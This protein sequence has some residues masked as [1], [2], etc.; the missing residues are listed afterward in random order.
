MAEERPRQSEA[1]Y[2]SLIRDHKAVKL[3]IDPQDGRIVDANRAAVSFYGW[4]HEE[5]THMFIQQIN[6][7]PTEVIKER[8]AQVQEGRRAHFEFQD[9]CAD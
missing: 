6:T 5:L 3:L 4:S 2:R 8:M 7:L 1:R 9:R